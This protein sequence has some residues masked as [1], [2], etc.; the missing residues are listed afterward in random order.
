MKQ[1]YC[2]PFWEQNVIFTDKSTFVLFNLLKHVWL[3]GKTFIQSRLSIFGDDFALLPSPPLPKTRKE[4]RTEI[5]SFDSA[6][7]VIV[8]VT[9]KNFFRGTYWNALVFFVYMFIIICTH[10]HVALRQ[11]QPNCPHRYQCVSGKLYGP[12]IK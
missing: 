12:V 8:A 5:D 7:I 10:L 4:S 2:S 1:S 9:T 6:E 3:K 11:L